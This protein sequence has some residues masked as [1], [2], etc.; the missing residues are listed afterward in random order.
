MSNPNT[1]PVTRDAP[2]PSI[3]L[4]PVDKFIFDGIQTKFLELFNVP[5]AWV[6]STDDVRILDRLFPDQNKTTSRY[7]YAFL[8]INTWETV[9]DRGNNRAMALRGIPVANSTDGK[10]FLYAR[11]LPI[12]FSVNVRFVSNSF[13]QITNFARTWLLAS[14]AGGF[15]F[16]V[17]YGLTTLDIRIV[18]D[19]SITFPQREASPENVQEYTAEVNLSVLGYVSDVELRQANVLDQVNITAQTAGSI[20]VSPTAPIPN[21]ATFWS[22]ASPVAGSQGLPAANFTGTPQYGIV[23][24][25]TVFTDTTTG[26]PLSWVWSFGDG[27]SST[28]QN[29]S[30]TYVTTGYFT[31]TLT[32]SNGLG[33]NTIAKTSFVN[34]TYPLPVA[35]FTANTQYGVFPLAVNFTDTTTNNPTAWLWDFGDGNTS[36]LQNPSHTYA[37]IGNY[38]ATL[39]AYNVGGSNTLSQPSFI[40]VVANSPVANFS[41]TPLTGN[42]PL[43]VNFTDLSTNVPVIWA[44]T[45]GDGG[46]SS[47]QNPSHT[48]L[49]SGSFNVSL[50]VTNS[51]GT[52][53]NTVANYVVVGQPAP[54]ANFTATP[55]TGVV[56]V[57]VS[58]T[59][60]SINSPT[61]WLWNFGDGNTNTSQNPT[62][63]YLL[64]GTY[65]VELT[66][67]NNSGSNSV[68]K[69]SYITLTGVVW[70][71]S[72]GN[73]AIWY[74]SGGNPA[75]WQST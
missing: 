4:E 46:T 71:D 20:P 15:S 45:F 63:K 58:F 27:G 14:K 74:D 69:T 47:L 54:V 39:T 43:T 51:G 2:S 29:P 12:S 24:F 23:P 64:P 56:P 31:V 68:T 75:I 62:H 50:M 9:E 48:Y 33:S 28:L 11:L 38:T 32:V 67:T 26:S 60:T 8:K 7:P 35:S 70:L 19:T 49:A 16:Q 18:A 55:L 66:A 65:T 52:D 30:H 3:T 59:D 17:E 53:T 21:P 25:T 5:T 22:Y 42:Y 36:T 10:S 41:G 57:T 44:W 37:T 72:N 1:Q 73:P 6:T 61:A 34:A 40:T 13:V